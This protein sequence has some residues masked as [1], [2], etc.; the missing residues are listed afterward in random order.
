M[1]LG[2]GGVD[3]S[4][5][6]AYWVPYDD[7]RADVLRVSRPAAVLAARYPDAAKALADIA[8]RAHAKP[9]DLRFLPLMSRRASWVA[10]IVQPDARIVGHL[11]LDGF[12]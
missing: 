7:T 1:T 6:P 11:P 3:L 8:A 2:L 9:D 5:V 12:F 10:L 4:M